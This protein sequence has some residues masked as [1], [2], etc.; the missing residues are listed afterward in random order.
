MPKRIEYFDYQNADAAG[1][2]AYDA[3]SKADGGYVTNMKKTLLRSLPAF[4]AL[5]EWYPLRDECAKFLDRKAIAVFC[6]SISAQND[7]LICS[8]FFVREFA[9]L[10][11]DLKSYEFTAEEDLL[12]RYGRRLVEAPNDVDDDLF[13]EL[14]SRYTQEQIVALTAFG[15][16]M[17]ATNLINNALNVELDEGLQVYAGGK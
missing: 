11:V 17:I 6:H 14:S 4:K 10:G 13:G 12:A 15:A 8:M 7:C 2:A 9:S 1:R 5:M 16:V 3:R